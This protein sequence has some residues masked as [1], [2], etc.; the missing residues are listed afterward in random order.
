VP[1]PNSLNNV[2]ADYQ[3]TL[4]YSRTPNQPLVVVI[5]ASDNQNHHAVASARVPADPQYRQVPCTFNLDGFHGIPHGTKWD[6]PP[7]TGLEPGKQVTVALQG[8]SFRVD[9]PNGIWIVLAD[10][11][12]SDPTVRD[13]ATPFVVGV[14][15]GDP[16]KGNNNPYPWNFSHTVTVPWDGVVNVT[17][18]VERAQVFPGA[19]SSLSAASGTLT[20]TP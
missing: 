7:C 6:F 17:I 8:A 14:Y 19:Q 20:I 15:P 5:D 1:W 12:D 18:W 3:G 16:V 11:I 9:G 10:F 2:A 13:E 4:I